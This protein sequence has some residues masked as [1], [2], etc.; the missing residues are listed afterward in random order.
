MRASQAVG[1]FR[2]VVNPLVAEHADDPGVVARLGYGAIWRDGI[3]GLK[4]RDNRGVSE[5]EQGIRTPTPGATTWSQ[6]SLIL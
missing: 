3:S 4:A 1:P 6:G 2:T 5:G